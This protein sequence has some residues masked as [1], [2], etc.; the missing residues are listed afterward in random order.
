MR[1]HWNQNQQRILDE[2]SRCVIVPGD[3]LTGK[4]T[5]IVEKVIQ[6]FANL[7]PVKLLLLADPM[8]HAEHV[9]WLYEKRL[10]EI[11]T[12]AV[13]R[14]RFEIVTKGIPRNFHPAIFGI[15]YTYAHVLLAD[16]NVSRIIQ[17]MN[18][19]D[20]RVNKQIFF[21]VPLESMAFD[22]AIIEL[23]HQWGAEA[24]PSDG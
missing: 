21:E 16:Y 5:V 13:C 2:T 1:K 17:L 11:C 15:P 10:Q 9:R 19:L 14:N 6:Y 3:R 8:K 20:H 22:H 7:N 12:D 24:V 23:H 4:S 18:A